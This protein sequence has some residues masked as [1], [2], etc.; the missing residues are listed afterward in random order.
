MF[1]LRCLVATTLFAGV[2][3]GLLPAQDKNFDMTHV[4]YAGLKDEILKHRGKVLVLD[5]WAGY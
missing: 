5:F 1:L 4:K 2:F 3:F